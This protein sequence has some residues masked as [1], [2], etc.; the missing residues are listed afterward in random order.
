MVAVRSPG[1]LSATPLTVIVTGTTTVPT[2]GVEVK[3]TSAVFT[4]PAASPLALNVI[5]T[6]K[7]V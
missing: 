2:S 4:V 3:V 6:S 5:G 7:L 1:T